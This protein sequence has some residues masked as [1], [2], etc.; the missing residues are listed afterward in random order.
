MPVIGTAKKCLRTIST[1]G[2]LNAP[3]SATRRNEINIA[4]KKR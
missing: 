4:R 2:L 1:H 3:Q